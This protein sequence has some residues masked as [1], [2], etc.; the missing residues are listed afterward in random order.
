[1]SP[2]KTPP[3]II[4]LTVLL[5]LF[6]FSGAARA[7]DL[8]LQSFGAV[9]DDGRDDA[10]ALQAALEQ[11]SADGGGRIIFPAGQTDILSP[12]SKDFLDQASSLTLTGINSGSRIHI[13][14]GPSA[15]GIELDNLE[16]VVIEKLVFHGTSV[17]DDS[18]PLFM[19]AAHAIRFSSCMRAVVRDCD[20]YGLASGAEDGSVLSAIQSDLHV[21]DSSFRGC[22]G[23]FYSNGA[24]LASQDWRGL[25]V[26]RVDF[27]DYGTLNGVYYSKT[28]SFAGSW[29]YTGT[30]RSLTDATGQRRIVIEDV[31][32]DEGAD[33]GLFV[34]GG[35]QFVSV[36]GL[37]CN[38]SGGSEGVGVWLNGVTRARIEQSWFGFTTS[39]RPGIQLSDSD[40]VELESVKFADGV[41]HVWTIRDTDWLILRHCEIPADARYPNGVRNEG[42]TRIEVIDRVPVNTVS[43]GA[44]NFTTAEGTKAANIV[45]TRT[46]DTSEAATLDYQTASGTASAPADFAPVHGALRFAAGETQTCFTVPIV[47]DADIEPAESINLV[48]SDPTDGARLGEQSTAVLTIT[49]DDAPMLGFAQKA[50]TGDEKTGSAVITVTRTGDMSKAVAV[51]YQTKDG[52][53]TDRSD[54]NF[55]VGV[56]RFAPDEAEKSFVIRI[57]DDAFVE[58]PETVLLTLD[59]PTGDGVLDKATATLTINSD[60]VA[61]VTPA[62]NPLG[63]ANFFVSQ[64]YADFLNRTPDAS[65]LAFWTKELNDCQTAECREV[66]RINVSAAFFLSV[67]FQGTGYFVYRV[68]Q[69]AHAS[70]ERLPLHDF[71]LETQ[72]ISSGVVVGQDGW[73]ERLE[74]NQQA[75]V[76]ELAARPEFMERYPAT[77]TPAGFIDALNR[78]TGGSLSQTERDALVS[79]LEAGTMS[80]ARALRAVAEDADFRAREFNRAFVLMQY[81][82]YLRRE[83]DA[84]GFDFW[85]R[86]LDEFGGDYVRAEMVKAFLDSAEFRQRFA[87]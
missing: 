3:L 18:D 68:N 75:Y 20:F 36:K 15:V 73:Q 77:L 7:G 62:E 69:A 10:P 84:A 30:P 19:D 22:V 81:F 11:L 71:L 42:N 6:S 56:L 48:I 57:T 47:D 66:K 70:G 1:M 31:R 80:R 8:S 52:T 33:K 86:K 12:V 27:L 58:D 40:I 9:A 2:Q 21:E 79:A 50:Y 34:S 13:A 37:N 38:V 61:S 85:L 4:G 51:R 28:P 17:P 29:I 76:E 64:H 39:N 5:F 26:R 32:M 43:F 55:A 24:V 87:A 25:T 78:N 16:S 54:Y 14:V 23:S 83:P 35:A 49:D 59:D 41:S 82:G 46:G 74:A 63:D 72:E 60:D 67:E 44:P 65:G 53:A 45:I